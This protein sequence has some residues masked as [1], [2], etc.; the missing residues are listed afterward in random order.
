MSVLDMLSKFSNLG[1][2][3]DPSLITKLPATLEKWSKFQG[4]MAGLLVEIKEE[5]SRVAVTVNAIDAVVNPKLPAQTVL[6]AIAVSAVDPRNQTAAPTYDKVGFYKAG[7]GATK[8]L[9][10]GG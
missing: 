10:N 9:E 1:D 4:D 5:L 3:F 8:E 2:N 7:D 6:D